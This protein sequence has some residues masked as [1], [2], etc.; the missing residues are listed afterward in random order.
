MVALLAL[1]ACAESGGELRDETERRRMAGAAGDSA[2]AD[3][4]A[5]ADPGRL[6]AFVT[7]DSTPAARAPAAA[8][9]PA[10][11][12]PD[13]PAPAAAEEWTAG[14]RAVPRP[15]AGIATLRDVRMGVNQ[16]FDRVVLDFGAGAVPGYRIGYVDRPV[17]QCGSGDVTPVAGDAWLLITLNATQ[18][19]DDN[20]RA[21][22]QGRERRVSMPVIREMEFIC[23]FEAE[24]QIVI[25]VASPNRYRVMELAS[26]GRLTIDI[27]H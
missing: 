6:P 16:G 12:A 23:D 14:D 15:N 27:Q 1:A 17:R 7:D 21:T 11:P 2:P 13:A 10:A 8:D 20:G 18:A 22:V 3:S 25:G 9:T 5:P 26:P 4:A 19:H 24:V